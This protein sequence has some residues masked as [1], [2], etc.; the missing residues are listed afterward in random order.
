[1][2][3]FEGKDLTCA[4]LPDLANLSAVAFPQEFDEVKAVFELGVGDDAHDV[5]FGSGGWISKIEKAK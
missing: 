5:R 1:L 4:D 3:D 2:A